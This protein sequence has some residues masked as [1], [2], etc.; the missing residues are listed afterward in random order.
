MDPSSCTV[1]YVNERSK[2]DRWVRRLS[3]AASGEAVVQKDVSGA[4]FSNEETD[5]VR[6]DLEALLSVF[7]QGRPPPF[8]YRQRSL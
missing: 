1:V 7:K 8:P 2:R 3:E 4:L 6:A 5:D